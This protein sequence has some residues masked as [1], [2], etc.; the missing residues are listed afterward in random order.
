MYIRCLT[1]FKYKYMKT[2]ETKIQ[3][4]EMTFYQQ[5]LTSYIKKLMILQNECQL[6]MLHDNLKFDY[7]LYKLCNLCKYKFIYYINCIN[8]YKFMCYINYVNLY[9]LGKDKI[10]SSSNFYLF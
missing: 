5:Y 8:L 3:N 9:K 4:T 6:S 7:N 1:F 2:I 10:W